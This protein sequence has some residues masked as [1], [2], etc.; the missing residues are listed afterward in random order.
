[1]ANNKPTRFED[2]EKELLERPGVR[3]EY[4]ALKP[5]YEIIRAI[6][7]RRNQLNISQKQLAKMI[8]TQQPAIA[9]LEKGSFNTTLG[10]LLKAA[11][12]LK[13]EISLKTLD[14]AKSAKGKI[15]V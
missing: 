8:G 9:R 1:M 2:F 3:K 11:N 5:K 14:T 13:L 10:T 7:E 4:E 12:A 15:R 6:I